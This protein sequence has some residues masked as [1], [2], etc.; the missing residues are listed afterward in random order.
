MLA[1]GAMLLVTSFAWTT[2]YAR[3]MPISIDWQGTVADT[4]IDVNQDGLQATL[5]DAQAKGS[6]GPT[7]LGV[8]TE[9]VFGGLCDSDPDVWFMNMWYSKP[10]VTFANGDQLWGNI[11]EGTGWM[12]LDVTTGEFSGDAK[13]VFTGG[14]GRFVGA[15]GNFAV[16]FDGVNLTISDLGVAFGAIRGE[17]VG[18]IE[19][20]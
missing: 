2:S 17:I 5:I 20:P 13:G 14:T 16:E 19:L 1:L 3:E 10:V 18:T 6:F 8:V 12:C 4:A 7:F 9:F 11:T 15:T